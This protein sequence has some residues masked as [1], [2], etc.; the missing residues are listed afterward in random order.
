M[1]HVFITAGTKGLG[2]KITEYFL[3]HGYQVTATYRSDEEQAQEMRKTYEQEGKRLHI[4][5]LD[6]L[7]HKQI[8][9][10]IKRAYEVFGRIDC[11]VSNAGPYI[12]K[13]KKLFDYSEEEWN[14]M[15]RG[16]LD[17]SFHLLKSCLPIMRQQQFGRIVFL[18]FQGV[19][20]SSGWIYRSAFAAAKVGV[21]SL[22]K[23]I[24]LEEAENKITANMVAPG[25]ITNDMK[26][27]NISE[28]RLV[29]DDETPIGR[30]GTGEDIARTV[31]YL[32]QDD[33]D[34]ITGSVIEVSGAMDVIHRYL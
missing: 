5:Q 27:K 12:F 8:P 20:H 28:S 29:Q 31:G 26:E 19:N 2:R 10:V 15:I 6:V 3:E 17:A 16:N 25:K 33:S 24:A 4:E 13:R 23:S 30:P 1:R 32:C 34:M 21:S 14:E 22:M 7:D 9:K 18:G 11:L